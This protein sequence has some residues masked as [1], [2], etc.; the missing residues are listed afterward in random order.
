SFHIFAHGLLGAGLGAASSAFH[1]GDILEGAASG[2]LG[3]ALSEGVMKLMEND[4]QTAIDEAHSNCKTK[5]ERLEFLNE[6]MRKKTDMSVLLS[7]CVATLLDLAPSMTEFTARNALEN[8]CLLQVAGAALTIW[9]MYDTYQETG[10]FGEVLKT[11]AVG[12]GA[13]II[14]AKG[15]QMGAKLVKG[16]GKAGKILSKK[17]VKQGKEHLKK[18]G[19]NSYKSKVDSKNFQEHHIISDKTDATK[20]HDLWKKAGMSPNDLRNKMLLPT[21]KG[22]LSSTTKR[23][24]H[25]GRHNASVN[26]NL[27]R[28]MNEVLEKSENQNWSQNQYKQKLVEIIQEEKSFLKS[29]DRIL[30]KNYRPWAKT[31]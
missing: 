24:I 26:K 5:E 18:Y 3:G 22:A 20:M 14:G 11:G 16:L 25:D 6:F 10:D 30:N 28:K 9:E 4:I 23:S 17:G 7:T 2:A 13:T 19:K 8:N 31:E 21:K 1:K 15:L 29:G 12:I 27:R